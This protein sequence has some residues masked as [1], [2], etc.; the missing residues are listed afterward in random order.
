MPRRHHSGLVLR[1]IP[2]KESSYQFPSPS[3]GLIHPYDD[4]KNVPQAIL[5]AKIGKFVFRPFYFPYF[6][7]PP[8]IRC[9]NL[10]SSLARECRGQSPTPSPRKSRKRSE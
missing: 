3:F 10:A 7:S 6:C 4:S 1:A 8:Q 5:G 2:L 9:G